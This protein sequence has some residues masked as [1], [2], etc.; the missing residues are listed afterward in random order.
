MNIIV[1]LLIFSVIVIFHEL[2]H[3]LL[4]K[5]NGITVNEFSVGMG[6]RICSF[7]KGTNGFRFLLFPRGNDI[8]QKE[9]EKRTIYSW[10]LLP[11]GGSC[12]MLGEDELVEDEGAFNKKGV[13]SRI[14]VIAAGPIF[15]FI[16]AFLL[17]LVVMA[18]VGFDRPVIISVQED[19]PMAE[20]GI[21]AG[22]EIVKFNGKK[23][24][25]G[26]DLSAYIQFHPLTE[27]PITIQYKRD[28]KKY[29]STL[30]PV[31]YEDTNSYRL[32]FGYN[33]AAREK[34]KGFDIVKYGAYEVKFWISTTIQSVGQL[35]TGKIGK[36][37]IAGPVGI[38]DMIGSE[39]ETAAEV[40]VWAVILS[41]MNMG[42]LLSAN[43]GVMNLLPIPALDGGRLVFLII[44]AFRGKPI[45]QEKEGMVHLIGL[46]ALMILMVFVMF[47]DLSRIF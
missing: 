47:N 28:G 34:A 13:G 36:D 22:D 21:Q 14:S 3:F 18:G 17:A 8:N 35:V 12:M 42:I 39:Y 9:F 2:G 1:A 25:I 32:G 11:I 24:Y 33:A 4:A 20:A 45:D 23:I 26:R 29:D 30:T 5:A 16:L 6:P 37:E 44:E 31:Y 46:V 15:N 40:G 38:V 7:A 27:K 10:K 43:L 19:G 41:M